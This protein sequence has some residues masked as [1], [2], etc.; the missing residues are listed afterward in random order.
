MAPT[1]HLVRHAQ[2]LHNLCVE[3]EAIRDP[4]LTPL[5]IR[6]CASLRASFPHHA[7]L[8]A[9]VASSMRRTLYTCIKS[10]GR[11]ETEAGEDGAGAGDIYPVIALD[12]L[13]EVSDA[14]SDTGSSAEKLAGEF[15]SD[16]VDLSR[17]RAGWTDKGEGS[18]FEP[19]LDKLAVRARE[20]RKTL[21]EIAG[22][23]DGHIAVVSHGAFLHFLTED[24]HGITNTYRKRQSS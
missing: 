23:G 1:I 7:Q 20:A 18:P 3:N 15:G 11:P 16:V 6:Q 12:T 13:Q 8:T 2:G 22:E 24:W 10:F 9:L 5:G 21:R 17:V 4:D 19:T 14:P